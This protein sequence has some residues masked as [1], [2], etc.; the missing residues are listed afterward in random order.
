MKKY[1]FI[2]LIIF[3]ISILILGCNIK[4]YKI[5]VY[6]ESEIFKFLDEDNQK[7]LD[8]LNKRYVVDKI[9]YAKEIISYTDKSIRFIDKNEDEVFLTGDKIEVKKIE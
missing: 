5:T 7:A 8:F 2:I 6:K 4:N 1:I 9:Y 3:L